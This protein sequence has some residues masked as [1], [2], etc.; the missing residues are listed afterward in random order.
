MISGSH[1]VSQCINVQVKNTQSDGNV[2][3]PTF[4]IIAI[5]HQWDVLTIFVGEYM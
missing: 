1:F 2:E 3:L 5:D 4:S